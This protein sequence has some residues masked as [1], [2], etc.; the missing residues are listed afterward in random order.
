MS[1]ER[2]AMLT[3]YRLCTELSL[4]ISLYRFVIVT[5]AQLNLGPLRLQGGTTTR[6]GRLEV[7]NNGVWGTVCDDGFGLAEAKVACTQIGYPKYAYRYFSLSCSHI[8][9]FIGM[10]VGHNL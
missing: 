2:K 5:A 3:S 10:I 4:D 7:Q 1:C 6:N 8:L 9:N